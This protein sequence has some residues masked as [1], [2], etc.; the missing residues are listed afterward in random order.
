MD[1]CIVHRLLRLYTVLAVTCLSTELV[2]DLIILF[3]SMSGTVAHAGPRKYIG[4]IEI[5]RL[6]VKINLLIFRFFVH[7]STI[8]LVLELVITLISSM[9]DKH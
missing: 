5:L 6:P 7:I 1:D 3:L 8:L 4:Y 2:L 9:I